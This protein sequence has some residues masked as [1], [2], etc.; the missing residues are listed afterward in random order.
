MTTLVFGTG[1]GTF[2]LLA[3]WSAALLLCFISLRTNRNVGPIAVSVAVLVMVVL[4]LIPRGPQSPPPPVD[5]EKGVCRPSELTLYEENKNT[6]Q[7][8]KRNKNDH[9]L[10]A[11]KEIEEACKNK[12]FN[13]NS[14][15][16]S[17]NSTFSPIKNTNNTAYPSTSTPCNE[18]KLDN[19]NTTKDVAVNTTLDL[20]LNFQVNALTDRCT[21]LE[22][23]LMQ[24]K[25]RHG[26][27]EFQQINYVQGKSP[28]ESSPQSF[29]STTTNT[30][31]N[32][33]FSLALAVLD[34][35]WLTDDIIHKY[36]N[37]LL[38]TVLN[39]DT[40]KRVY[41]M[42][43]AV[44]QAIK[45]SEDFGEFLVPL[46]EQNTDYVFIPINDCMN[47]TNA[48]LGS[49]WSLLLY[50]SSYH[51][52]FY[53]DSSM[54]KTY[55][56]SHAKKVA[57]KIRN[58][59]NSK[60]PLSVEIVE[61]PMQTTQNDCG[62]HL[63]LYT[64]VLI[65][66]IKISSFDI[67][68]EQLS[69]QL[70]GI[71]PCDIKTKRAQLAYM[72][73]NSKD[74]LADSQMVAD[75]MHKGCFENHQL[76]KFTQFEDCFPGVK[77][78]PK[79]RRDCSLPDGSKKVQIKV[80]LFADSQGKGLPEIVGRCSKGLIYMDGLVKSG[81]NFEQIY[82]QA[83]ISLNRPLILLAGTN[84]VKS[85]R[86][87]PI[88]K[89]MEHMLKSL[90][91]SRPVYVTT[92]PPRFDVH[93]DDS[94]HYD[95]A[96]VNSYIKELVTRMKNVTLLDLGLFERDNFTTHGLHLNFKGKKKLAYMI[97]D[98]LQKSSTN[99]T[100]KVTLINSSPSS[101]QEESTSEW[102]DL[103]TSP[104]RVTET[105]MAKVIWHAKNNKST[106]IAH[107]IS[108]DFHHPRHMTAGV[109][110]VIKKIFGKPTPWH[111]RSK[112]LAVQECNEGV[113]VFSLITKQ[114]YFGKPILHDYDAAFSD[115]TTEFKKKNL[116]H[117]ICSPIGCVRDKVN[118]DHFIRNVRKFQ[119]VTKA[120][121]TI[122]SYYQKS[123]RTLRNGMSHP[124][125]VK[126][127]E[128]LIYQ[129]SKE[130]D[131]SSA[132]DLQQSPVSPRVT[133]GHQTYS[134]AVKSGSVK[135]L[136][137]SSDKVLKSKNINSRSIC[138]LNTTPPPT[139]VSDNTPQISTTTANTPQISAPTT[140]TPSNTPPPT[141]TISSHVQQ[142]SNQKD[143]FLGLCK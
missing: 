119:Q 76:K 101:F 33:N 85:K 5:K 127:L 1:V 75:M 80:D 113:T 82:N 74:M 47:L 92:I 17:K 9:L 11:I 29:D 39:T 79:K 60:E 34:N 89:K 19:H 110:V 98:C 57:A 69:Q 25:Y 97:I 124:D 73:Y 84:D 78:N 58:H 41:L 64:D 77:R 27:P 132:I 66:K 136:K 35:A 94:L 93:P 96:Q 24:D 32:D 14:R 59:L 55:N 107:S 121:V 44:A 120:T 140:I 42:S 51:R 15:N 10:K 87:E 13:K 138:L 30:N 71:K 105:H 115:L 70:A 26:V 130:E 16:L 142:Q 135:V 52:F 122:V 48:D 103:P 38:S 12:N 23:S 54:S 106:G 7:V 90:S 72:L 128:D 114:N 143:C 61:V 102:E 2:I 40:D 118:T 45:C 129:N 28:P 104:I 88:L 67:N 81:A 21:Q 95:I 99:V 6:L 133:P 8:N 68:T 137:Q 134:A 83:S 141:T 126:E 49:H 18:K 111:R 46:I 100:N 63:L 65:N 125:F 36:F 43:L 22:L 86:P 123:F 20:D 4:L 56:L 116:K 131:S 139:T 31:T 50:V 109:A 108:A 37:I 3:V 117:L 62:V 112:H 53:F 91:E